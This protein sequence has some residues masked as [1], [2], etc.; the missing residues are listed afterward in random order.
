MPIINTWRGERGHNGPPWTKLHPRGGYRNSLGQMDSG[1][2]YGVWNIKVSVWL[3]NWLVLY[4]QTYRV[5]TRSTI[6][7]LLKQIYIC[8]GI[9]FSISKTWSPLSYRGY[10]ITHGMQLTSFGKHKKFPEIEPF[11][12]LK[13]SVL[14][15]ITLWN[16]HCSLSYIVHLRGACLSTVLCEEIGTGFLQSVQFLLSSLSDG[17]VGVSSYFKQEEMGWHVVLKSLSFS[18]HPLGFTTYLLLLQQNQHWSTG[19]WQCA[20]IFSA[21][22]V[23][24]VVSLLI[25]Q[26][27]T[28]T[29]QNFGPGSDFIGSQFWTL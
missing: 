2:S 19:V 26:E 23:T 24:P 21:G 4:T 14:T 12:S 7:W 17:K 28:V 8:A 22:P 9:E 6:G 20:T 18:R 29:G 3:I 10:G 15:V 25:L 5:T 1:E 11:F 27:G 16:L 13:C